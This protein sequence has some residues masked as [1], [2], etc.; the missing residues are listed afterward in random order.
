PLV[1]LS[2][3]QH[4]STQATTY[5]NLMQ[6]TPEENENITTERTQPYISRPTAAFIAFICLASISAVL[7]ILR[8]DQR[9][10]AAMPGAAEIRPIH[11]ATKSLGAR[12]LNQ[13]RTAVRRSPD[14]A[15]PS[16]LRADQ[17]PALSTNASAASAG[18]PSRPSSS[19]ATAQTSVTAGV[20][21]A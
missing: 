7:I 19:G 2:I 1:A 4:K 14:P 18:S 15:P 6:V 13:F 8:A 20:G 21:E 11:L 10:T 17:T 9:R 5:P 12:Q 16:Q 3:D